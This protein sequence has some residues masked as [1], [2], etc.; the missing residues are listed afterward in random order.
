MTQL[1][2]PGLR[3]AGAV[4]IDLWYHMKPRE[5]LPC[6]G[7]ALE[8]KKFCRKNCKNQQ[9]CLLS[10][11]TPSTITISKCAPPEKEGIFD[12]KMPLKILQYGI[13]VVAEP[14]EEERNGSVRSRLGNSL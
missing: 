13:R 1:G 2:A 5:P 6:V 11:N 12:T 9:Y 10:N 7:K 14:Q 8:K 3:K 4:F